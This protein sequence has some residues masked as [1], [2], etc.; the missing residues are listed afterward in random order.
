MFKITG[1]GKVYKFATLDEAK[2]AARR[3]FEATGDIVGIEA[4]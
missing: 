3:V 1:Y 4:A 2:D